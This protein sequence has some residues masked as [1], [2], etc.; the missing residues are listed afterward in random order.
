VVEGLGSSSLDLNVP[1]AVN[2]ATGPDLSIP[3]NKDIR[4]LVLVSFAASDSSPSAKRSGL[5][6]F[7]QSLEKRPVLRND[8]VAFKAL[9]VVHRLLQQVGE[10]WGEMVYE[11]VQGSIWFG[12]TFTACC[13]LLSSRRL[14]S[15]FSRRTANCHS[16]ITSARRGN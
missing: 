1:R 5:P 14:P 10:S 8:V 3:R 16:S 13:P 7:F 2:K 12:S 11:Q 6:T 15:L 4:N 9:H